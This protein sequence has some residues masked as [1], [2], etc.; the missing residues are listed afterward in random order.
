MIIGLSIF[1]QRVYDCVTMSYSVGS[2]YYQVEASY[3]EL[4]REAGLT[5]AMSV[6]GQPSYRCVAFDPGT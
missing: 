1:P 5:D 6:F 3:A 4:V 2:G